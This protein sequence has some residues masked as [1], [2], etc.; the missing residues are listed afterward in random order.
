MSFARIYA[1]GIVV[2][3]DPDRVRIMVVDLACIFSHSGYRLF[4]RSSS[5]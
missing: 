4:A 3:L 5:K 1:G 2:Y